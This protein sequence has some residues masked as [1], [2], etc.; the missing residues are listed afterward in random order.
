[1]VISG[2]YLLY[3][4][5]AFGWLHPI[6][7]VNYVGNVIFGTHSCQ[8]LKPARQVEM[9][10]KKKKHLCCN[11]FVIFINWL[12]WNPYLSGTRGAKQEVVVWTHKTFSAPSSLTL[13][14]HAFKSVRSSSPSRTFSTTT[15]SKPDK[16]ISGKSVKALRRGCM[17]SYEDTAQVVLFKFWL[18]CSR[19]VEILHSFHLPSQSFLLNKDTFQGPVLELCHIFWQY[20]FHISITNLLWHD[21]WVTGC[22]DDKGC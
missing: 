17:C 19:G 20:Y 10:F 4:V 3:K 22:E 6:C 9:H 11:C 15:G 14:S 8:L 2:A 18:A 16:S 5:H 21:L 1:M 7:I 12:L 13:S